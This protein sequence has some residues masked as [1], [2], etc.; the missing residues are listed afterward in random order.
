VVI[1]C[2]VRTSTPWFQTVEQDADAIVAMARVG[3]DGPTGGFF[4]RAGRVP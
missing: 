4:D 3:A 2:A 1:R